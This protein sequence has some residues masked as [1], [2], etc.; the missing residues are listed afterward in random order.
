MREEEHLAR[1][2]GQVT[3]EEAQAEAAAEALDLGRH[4]EM[5]AAHSKAE[6]ADLAMITT[7]TSWQEAAADADTTAEAVVV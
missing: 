1:A 5:V 2:E 3:E 7:L 4:Q 6:A